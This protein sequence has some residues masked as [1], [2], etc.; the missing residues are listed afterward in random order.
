MAVQPAGPRG[1]IIRPIVTEKSAMLRNFN[2]Y[3]FAVKPEAT[4]GAITMAVAAAY[5]VKPIAVR[6]MPVKGRTRRRGNQLGRTG[7]W[8]KAFV[9]LPEGKSITIQEG[10]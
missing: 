1:L 9:T 3:V 2:Q 10:V 8:K 5:G 6:L 7:S 4:K